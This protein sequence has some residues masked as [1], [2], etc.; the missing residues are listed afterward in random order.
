MFTSRCDHCG[1]TFTP[2]PPT[3]AAVNWPY[4]T[5]IHAGVRGLLWCSLCAANCDVPRRLTRTVCSCSAWSPCLTELRRSTRRSPLGVCYFLSREMYAALEREASVLELRARPCHKRTSNWPVIVTVLS[6]QGLR[7]PS[8]RKK[9]KGKNANYPCLLFFFFICR[10][11]SCN[12]LHKHPRATI[13]QQLVLAPHHATYSRLRLHPWRMNK[14]PHTS[15]H[16][17]ARPQAHSR[18][19]RQNTLLLR[20]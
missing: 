13:P 10:S 4:R 8:S 5:E 17:Q 19:V 7:T 12:T 1:Q 6:F 3:T 9:R 11:W 18:D 20:L 15:T 2:R 16:K 14:Y